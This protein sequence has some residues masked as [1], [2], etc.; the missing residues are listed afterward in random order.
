MNK[1]TICGFLLQQSTNVGALL[2]QK[3]N[4]CDK[5]LMI[6]G[7]SEYI[8]NKCRCDYLLTFIYVINVSVVLIKPCIQ[9]AIVY[10][11]C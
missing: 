9:R 6:L 7:H 11:P 10:F 1:F 3:E 4:V 5:H 2:L 8:A